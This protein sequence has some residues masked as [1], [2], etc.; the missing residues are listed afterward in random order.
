M[1]CL[2]IVREDAP[3]YD[4]P[5]RPGLSA[6][7]VDTSLRRAAGDMVR[8]ERNVLLWF[9]EMSR[10]KLH[11]DLG[12]ATMQ[13]YATEVLGFSANLVYCFERLA[14]DL[15]RLPRLRRAV[16]SGE[17]GWTKARVLVRV[18]SAH[19]ERTW[20]AKAKCLSRRELQREVEQAKRQAQAARGAV[21]GQTELM[22]SGGN[23]SRT[24]TFT[25]PRTGRG[26]AEAAV[27]H[28]AA[29]GAEGPP[30]TGG[31]A[32]D[33]PGAEA[34]AADAL[35]ADAPVS[36]HFRL[37]PLDLARYEALLEGIY[38]S[39]VVSASATREEIL[40]SALD[41]L[42]SGGNSSETSGRATN[43]EADP[44]AEPEKTGQSRTRVRNSTPYSIVIYR[45]DACRNAEV[46][47]NRGR[48][49]LRPSELEAAECDAI[50]EVEGERGHSTIAPSVRRAVLRRDGDVCQAPGCE[51]TGFLEVHH[52]KPRSQGGSNRPENLVTLCSSCH[53]L[54][55]EKGWGVDALR[56][57]R[58][59][60]S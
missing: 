11:A 4:D 50:L 52:I 47:T 8:A 30:A 32:P 44:T 34:P 60:A 26:Q 22:P 46:R 51:R 9:M 16:A 27:K 45:C 55:H 58:H 7:Q 40:L 5:F 37:T 17:L 24:A 33:A 12:Y 23:G 3:S 14:G 31:A 43:V 42:L 25:P 57:D 10:R 21:S 53:R 54:W 19:N 15:D 18:A 38:K 41:A 2:H 6:A 56:R 36:V 20:I 49:R 39:R 1:P 28:E 29:V 59:R 13:H 35:T 48:K